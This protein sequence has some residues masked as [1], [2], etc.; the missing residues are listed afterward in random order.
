MLLDVGER[1]LRNAALNQMARSLHT[2]QVPRGDQPLGLAGR[3]GGVNGGGAPPQRNGRAGG[4]A[5]GAAAALGS[6]WGPAAVSAGR[7][8][9]RAQEDIFARLVPNI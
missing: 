1:K 2:L 5:L 7:R 6:V 4:L 9:E 3:A 8:D